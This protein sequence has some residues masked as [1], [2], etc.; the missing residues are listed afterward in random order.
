MATR[1]RGRPAGSGKKTAEEGAVAD[2]GS[3]LEQVQAA[4]NK[5]WG[6]TTIRR[7]SENMQPFRIPTGIFSLDLATCGGIAHNRVSMFKGP[8]HSG[9]TTTS[10][11][12]I[13]GAQ[14]SL[15]GQQVA[16]VDAEGTRDSVWGGKLGV[17][18]EDLVYTATETG[19]QAVDITEA[20]IRTKEISLVVVDS[21]ASLV[22]MKEVAGSAEDANVALQARLISL[23]MRKATSALISERKRNH[24]V[25][26]LLINQQRVKI[27]GWAPNGGEPL[28]SPGGKALEHATT[29]EFNF[30]NKENTS[31]DGDGVDTLEYNEHAFKIQ[32]NK[33]NAG[34]RDGEF[35]LMRRDSD[36]FPLVE[37]DIDDAPSMLAHAKKTGCYTGGGK[38]WKLSIPDFDYTFQNSDE[39]I[40][41]LYENRDIYWKLRCHLIASHA[42]KL[43]MPQYFIDYLY[44]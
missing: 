9:K 38:S 27:G 20:L 37:G 34:L 36:K 12:V 11:K 33:L 42:A 14:L 23:F 32:K 18:N 10:E 39:A 7:A 28:S 13:A 22:P 3:E 5:R 19:E 21:I 15:P 44:G 16:F 43:G 1:G 29:M 8:K 35:Q 41:Y 24:F 40:L 2:S 6:A 30:K 25:T 17:N 31:K 4:I 26:L